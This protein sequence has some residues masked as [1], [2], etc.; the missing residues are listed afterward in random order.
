[1][2]QRVLLIDNVDSFT[3]NLVQVL[4]TLGAEVQVRRADELDPSSPEELEAL[5]PTHVV[6]SPGPGRPEAARGSLAVAEHFLERVPLLG[7]CLGHQCLGVVAGALVVSSPEPRHGETVRV[8]H[9]GRGL[10]RGLSNPME[11]GR[12]HSLVVEEAS[13]PAEYEISGWSAEGEVLALRHRRL[14]VFGLQFHPESIL[15]PVGPRLIA[16][17]LA[18]ESAPTSAPGA[19]RTARAARTEVPA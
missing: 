19:A 2:K 1:M 16:S 3:F 8:Y 18:L 5:D 17:F 7:V 4:R 6:L 12:Y 15:T 9:D 11:A 13:V 14:P 10:F